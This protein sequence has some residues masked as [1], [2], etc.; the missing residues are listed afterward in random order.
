M[1][2]D[3]DFAGLRNEDEG[4][5]AESRSVSWLGKQSLGQKTLSSLHQEKRIFFQIDVASFGYDEGKEPGSNFS[6]LL[7]NCRT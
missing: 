5:A 4:A 3:E 2:G 1:G 7:M 6:C